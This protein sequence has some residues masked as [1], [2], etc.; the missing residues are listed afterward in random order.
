MPEEEVFVSGGVN[1]IET[2]FCRRAYSLLHDIVLHTAVY[3]LPI[4]CLFLMVG[5]GEVHLQ[6]VAEVLLH[7]IGAKFNSCLVLGPPRFQHTPPPCGTPLK[8]GR[9][10]H[11]M[12]EVVTIETLNK[13]V[14]LHKLVVE[15]GQG[16]WPGVWVD[17]PF[18]IHHD[19]QPEAQTGNVNGSLLY[20]YA[21]NVVLDDLSFEGSASIAYFICSRGRFL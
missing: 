10:I 15:V 3:Q 8:R 17:I 7:F 16:L 19:T 12:T 1:G 4:I 20:V 14:T 9:S 2:G 21:V 6:P 18:C 5:E 13:A 11:N